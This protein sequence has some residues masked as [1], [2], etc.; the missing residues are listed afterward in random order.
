MQIRLTVTGGSGKCGI[1]HTPKARRKGRTNEERGDL[2]KHQCN[3]IL[4]CT[5]EKK[6]K[7]DSGLSP[8]VRGAPPGTPERPPPSKPLEREERRRSVTQPEARHRVLKA[9]V[10]A[11]AAGFSH[12]PTVNIKTSEVALC[13]TDPV[14]GYPTMAM[15]EVNAITRVPLAN[16]DFNRSIVER[17]IDLANLAGLPISTGW[18]GKNEENR[19]LTKIHCYSLKGTT[20]SYMRSVEKARSAFDLDAEKVIEIPD[21]WS[22]MSIPKAADTGYCFSTL[23]SRQQIKPLNP[24]SIEQPKGP[25]FTVRGWP[26]QDD[27]RPTG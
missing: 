5:E 1:G 23:N 15:E 24:I 25:S 19:R 6:K 9:S 16:T 22:N 2:S 3:K 27:G 12:L 20:N 11:R 14:S 8:P 17:G 18:F 10:V 4:Y 7:G 13:E 26:I 21:K